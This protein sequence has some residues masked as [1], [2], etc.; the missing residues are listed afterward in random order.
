LT[1][2]VCFGKAYGVTH[3][4]YCLVCGKGKKEFEKRNNKNKLWLFTQ[5]V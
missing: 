2:Q 4:G 3:Y 1:C 5:R